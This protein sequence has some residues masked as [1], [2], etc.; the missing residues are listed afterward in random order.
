MAPEPV[1]IPLTRGMVALVD[2]EDAERVRAYRWCAQ[3]R[4]KR[5]YAARSAGARKALIYMHRMILNVDGTPGI[6]RQVDHRNGN[7]LD[8]RRANL[9]LCTPS[10]NR[11]NAP[12]S[13]SNTSGV[14]GVR[15]DRQR[16]E[17]Q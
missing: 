6:K 11:V 10:E 9:R 17:W 2:A 8:N 13:A 14:R 16:L 3:L 15:W 5:V 7:G 4:G 12:A 1:K